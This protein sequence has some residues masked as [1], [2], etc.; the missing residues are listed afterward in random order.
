MKWNLHLCYRSS[1]NTATQQRTSL[2]FVITYRQH[3]GQNFHDFVTELKKL[4]PEC[5]FET[6]YDSLIKD[7]IVCGMND[8]CLRERLL[9]ETELTLPKVMLLVILPKRL[10][11]M[12]TKFLSLMRPSI[13][14][15]FQNT[16]HLKVKPPQ[17]HLKTLTNT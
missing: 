11:N 3:E 2:Y 5:E 9:R 4:I 6:L 7:M 8:N 14:T 15:R 1:L 12:P 10:V 13:C 16:Q 17:K